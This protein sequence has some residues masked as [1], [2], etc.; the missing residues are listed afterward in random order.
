MGVFTMLITERFVRDVPLAFVLTLWVA[1]P[2][3][4][5]PQ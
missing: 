2:A 4:A 3:S 1:Q 5:A